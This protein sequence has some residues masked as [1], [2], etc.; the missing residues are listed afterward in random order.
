MHPA[1]MFYENENHRK[2][3]GMSSSC[4]AGVRKRCAGRAV[5][6]AVRGPPDSARHQQVACGR[7]RELEKPNATVRAEVSGRKC[8][9]MS[10][11]WILSSTLRPI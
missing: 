7:S 8:A 6:R 4:A 3:R 10:S 1:R 5:V 9:S 2:L 11:K